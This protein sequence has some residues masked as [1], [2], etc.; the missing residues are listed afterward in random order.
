MTERG[1]TQIAFGP[2]GIAGWGLLVL[3]VV[4]RRRLLALMG[5]AG[6]VADVTVAELGRFNA[7]N[8]PE[9]PPDS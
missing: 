1:Q 2:V 4:L 9:R 6:V 3:G 8:E 5:L 7:A